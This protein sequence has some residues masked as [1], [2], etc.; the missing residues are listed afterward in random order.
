MVDDQKMNEIRYCKE[1]DCLTQHF[2]LSAYESLEK[3]IEV[4]KEKHREEL[5]EKGGYWTHQNFLFIVFPF[6]VSC[7]WWIKLNIFGFNSF[8]CIKLCFY[9]WIIFKSCL[10]FI[11]GKVLIWREHCLLICSEIN[12]MLQELY[13][14]QRANVQRLIKF[15]LDLHVA[16]F[17][18]G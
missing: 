17:L 7:R 4:L 8:L 1:I 10:F 11:K 6:N 9:I 3:S 16:E 14:T 15:P 13:F 12:W 2:L 5:E 18:L